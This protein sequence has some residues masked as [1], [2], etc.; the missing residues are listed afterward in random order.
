MNRG[1]KFVF[2]VPSIWVIS[3]L[4]CQAS[5][6]SRL[7]PLFSVR[8]TVLKCV[9]WCQYH[10]VCGGELTDD[11][12]SR[13]ILV[14]QRTELPHITATYSF[15]TTNL[16]G[17]CSTAKL[18]VASG[19]GRHHVAEHSPWYGARAPKKIPVL[20]HIWGD[21]FFFPL[22]FLLLRQPP[23]KNYVYRDHVM[24]KECLNRRT[25]LPWGFAFRC[26]GVGW[27]SPFQSICP[28]RVPRTPNSQS[29]IPWG[30]VQSDVVCSCVQLFP[31]ASFIYFAPSCMYSC[32]DVASPKRLL[33]RSSKKTSEETWR[34]C[35]HV[36]ARGYSKHVLA[37][38]R[39]QEFPP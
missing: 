19:K 10:G 26:C 14:W 17:S 18:W 15:L 25:P 30:G 9:T 37:R 27:I 8:M 11:S 12:P 23:G 5:R 32:S 33:L 28:T 16:S 21:R 35:P 6:I 36:F 3:V 24:F 31:R 2:F 29:V 38:S 39:S 13:E 7:F 34:Q 20:L 22:L 4:V 1:I